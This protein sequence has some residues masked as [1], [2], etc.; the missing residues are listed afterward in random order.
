MAKN[1]PRRHHYV[2]KFYQRGFTEGQDRLW[3]YDRKAKKFSYPSPED[4]CCE[5]DMYT[6]DP[7]GQR[8]LRIEVEWFSKIDSDGAEAIRHF[9]KEHL[10]DEWREAFSIFMAQQIT[11]TPVFRRSTMASQRFMAEEFLRLTFSD[12]KRARQMMESHG[13]PSETENISPESMVKAV[14]GSHIKVEITEAPFLSHMIEQVEFLRRWLHSFNWTIL[15]AP[16]E[17]GFITCDYPFVLIPPKTHPTLTGF[18]YPGTVMLFPLDRRMCLHIEGR[19]WA[20]RFI[21]TSKSDVLLINQNVAV[22]SER[23]IIGPNKTQLESVIT[24]SGTAAPDTNVRATVEIVMAD[25]DESLTT[26]TFWPI[27]NYF[28]P[29]APLT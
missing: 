28:Y 29:I 14:T 3:M 18:R 7:K 13:D 24:R 10:S 2:P 26:M 20:T 19:G 6:I 5:N 11:R 12:V 9:R 4:I 16:Q 1:L 27:R 17:T 23:F 22:N 8:D 15:K 21:S 25:A